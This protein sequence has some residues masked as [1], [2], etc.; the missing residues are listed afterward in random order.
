MNAPCKKNF[1]F[2]NNFLDSF[3]FFSVAQTQIQSSSPKVFKKEKRILYF[4]NLKINKLGIFI[5]IY[6]CFCFLF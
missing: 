1:F 2:F 5:D 4:Y 3:F 6:T